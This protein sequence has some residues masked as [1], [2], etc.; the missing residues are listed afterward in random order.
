MEGGGGKERT[1][2]GER[3]KVCYNTHIYMYMYVQ[4]YMEYNA[5]VNLFRVHYTHIW[6]YYNET[7]SYY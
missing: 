7:P 6:S 5:G 3:I 2:R 1:L 4:I